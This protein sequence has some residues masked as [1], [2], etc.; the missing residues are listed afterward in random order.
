MS[1]VASQQ[2][3]QG[4]HS[5]LVGGIATFMGAPQVEADADA[6][7]AAGVKAAFLGMPFDSTTIARPGAELGPRT[8][9]RGGVERHAEE[10]CLHPRRSQGVGV[11]LHLWGAHEGGD[12]AHEDGVPPLAGLLRSDGAHRFPSLIPAGSRRTPCPRRLRVACL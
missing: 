11:S 6:L 2:T 1:S 12:P 10:G 7:R 8:R 3:R 9:D 5:V 4:W